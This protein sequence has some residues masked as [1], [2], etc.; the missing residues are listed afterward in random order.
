MDM[1]SS[2]SHLSPVFEPNNLLAASSL[3]FALQANKN[4]LPPGFENLGANFPNDFFL[5]MPPANNNNSNNNNNS[6]NNNN[7]SNLIN[8]NHNHPNDNPNMGKKRK[9]TDTYPSNN[10]NNPNSNKNNS[11]NFQQSSNNHMNKSKQMKRDIS[12][13]SAHSSAMNSPAGSVFDT[14]KNLDLQQQKLFEAVTN[15]HLML[16]HKQTS[17]LD[18]HINQIP[19]PLLP[20][21]AKAADFISSFMK[22]N[23]KANNSN[24]KQKSFNTP[25]MN[26]GQ[27][28]QHKMPNNNNSN[29]SNNNTNNPNFNSNNGNMKKKINPNNNM[30]MNNNINNNNSNNNN[31]IKE[32]VRSNND[33]FQRE[34]EIIES[35]HSP[36]I[37]SSR[38]IPNKHMSG[39]NDNKRRDNNNHHHQQH[40]QQQQHNSKIY[41]K[42]HDIE[43]IEIVEDETTIFTPTI[44]HTSRKQKS[45]LLIIWLI[46][47][48]EFR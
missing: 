36:I 20:E 5:N 35:N 17:L 3:I 14:F 21:A 38:M 37:P 41:N 8:N 32:E 4:Q 39:T 40:N 47:T 43:P 45:H 6:I 22:S 29:N 28:N 12:S 26:S 15:E 16:N 13:S 9:I 18:E 31:R 25:Q 1:F 10:P 44:N 24:L 30:N 34:C 48:M 42:T 33:S 23:K 2:L 46:R 7:N 11:N 27:Q 19:V